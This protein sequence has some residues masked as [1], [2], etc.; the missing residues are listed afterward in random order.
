MWMKP[1]TRPVNCGDYGIGHPSDLCGARLLQKL[2]PTHQQ[3]KYTIKMKK[4]F[5]LPVLLIIAVLPAFSQKYK[6]AA[7]TAALNKEYAKVSSNIAALTTR[8]DEAQSDLA[9]YNRK[10]DKAS[11]D[12]QSTAATTANKASHATNGD[13]RDARRA[14]K[15]ARRSVKD[16]KDSRKADNNVDDQNKKIRKLTAELAKN[17]ERLQELETMRAAISY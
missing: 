3:I 11:S 14:K 4:I 5:L 1:V 6:T 13:V 9:K 16:A 10:S 2:I 8:L 12:A 17:K 15:E 7:D